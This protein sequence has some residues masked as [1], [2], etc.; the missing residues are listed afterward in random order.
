M[1]VV[2]VLVEEYYTREKGYMTVEGPEGYKRVVE[3][4]GYMKAVVVL[5]DCMKVWTWPQ[6]TCAP[7]SATSVQC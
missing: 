6:C 1:K 2:Q 3:L 7:P 4:V 5:G